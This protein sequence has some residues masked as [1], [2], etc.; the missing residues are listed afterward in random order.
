MKLIIVRH[1]ETLANLNGIIQGQFN[2]PLTQN[3]I[4]QAKKVSQRL[5]DMK[6]DFAFSSDLDRTMDTCIE[7]LKFHKEVKLIP[8]PILREQAKGIFDG[9]TREERDKILKNENIYP[10]WC[11]EGGESLIEVWEKVIP[12]LEKI[13]KEHSDKNILLVSHGGPIS[14]LLTY[15]QNKDIQDF[16]DYL[17][18]E[19]TAISI[20]N[21]EKDK[22]RFEVLNCSKHLQ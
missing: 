6:I 2:S 19:N 15:L 8:T 9:K 21:I 10:E 13:K 3:G 7:I 18:K 1:G 11:P 22:I 16:K 4:E 20:V 14:C 5:K 17:P 12:F